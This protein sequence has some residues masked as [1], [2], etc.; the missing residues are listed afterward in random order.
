MLMNSL[1]RHAVVLAL[2]GGLAAAPAAAQGPGSSKPKHKDRPELIRR[3][4]SRS[5]QKELR[6][7]AD[8]RRSRSD[9]RSES[10]RAGGPPFCRSGEGHPVHG[11]RWCEEKG[12]GLGIDFGRYDDRY[13]DRY[14]DRYDD[15]SRSRD[16]YGS[17]EREHEQFHLRHDRECRIRAAERPLDLPWQIRVRQD[18][19]ERH[20]EWHDRTGTRHD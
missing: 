12:Y 10:E 7:D 13:E 20:D 14:D 18:C 19:K 4:D 17:Y 3:G 15:R 16:G 5:A 11:R 8:R 2:L 1:H 6:K 9:V